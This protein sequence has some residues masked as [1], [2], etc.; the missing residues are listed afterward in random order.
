VPPIRA[1]Q[2]EYVL[3][4]DA[5]ANLSSIPNGVTDEQVLM[6]PDMSTGFSGAESG[7]VRIGDAVMVF[8]LRPIGL[9]AVAGAKLMGATTII[10]VDT[11]QQRLALLRKP[12]AD[13]VVRRSRRADRGRGGRG[14][15]QGKFLPELF[16]TAPDL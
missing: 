6:C 2:A 4:K 9:C 13:H 5:M 1:G 7:R 10:G 16:C 3:V 11:V 15:G 14:G 12:G 8:A